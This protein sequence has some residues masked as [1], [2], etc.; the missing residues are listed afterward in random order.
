MNKMFYWL[1]LS[2]EQDFVQGQSN[3]AECYE[4]GYGTSI[5]MDKAIYW[6]EKAA[7][8][9]YREAIDALQRIRKADND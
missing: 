1:S 7:R 8:Q 9:G 6:Y 3:L 5:D 2:A 4:K